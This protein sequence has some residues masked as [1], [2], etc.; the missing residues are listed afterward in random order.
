MMRALSDR[1]DQEEPQP[2]VKG[3]GQGSESA[4]DN[5]CVRGWMSVEDPRSADTS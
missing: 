1:P 5:L 3:N 4:K 2:W